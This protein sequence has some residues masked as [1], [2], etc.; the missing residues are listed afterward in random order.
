MLQDH[1]HV[2]VE[3]LARLDLVVEPKKFVVNHVSDNQPL[4][5]RNHEVEV[6]LGIGQVLLGVA[7]QTGDLRN[8]ELPLVAKLV[9]C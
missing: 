9:L 1:L 5:L 4:G 6:I 7:D 3:R 2:R 8:V